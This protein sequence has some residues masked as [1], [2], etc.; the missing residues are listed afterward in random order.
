MKMRTKHIITFVFGILASFSQAQATIVGV[1][2]YSSIL[3]D[4]IHMTVADDDSPTDATMLN[5]WNDTPTQRIDMQ[6]EVDS[7]SK[8]IIFHAK[9]SKDE[10][11]RDWEIFYTSIKNERAIL[12]KNC[13]YSVRHMMKESLRIDLK[14]NVVLARSLLFFWLPNMGHYGITLPDT[15]RIHLKQELGNMKIPFYTQYDGRENL[16]TR[17]KD[18]KNDLA[19]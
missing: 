5:V 13:A 12:G 1:F 10:I 6:E 2:M 19:L 4:H 16:M 15:V 11:I 9:K 3:F 14:N 7:S 8:F 17:I 18:A